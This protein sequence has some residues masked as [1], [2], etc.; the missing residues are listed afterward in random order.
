MQLGSLTYGKIDY[1]GSMSPSEPKPPLNL[2]AYMN[3]EWADAQS[4]SVS[5][6]DSGF[7]QGLTVVEQLRTFG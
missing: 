3:G 5:I 1:D 2:T 4:L 7:M 6:Y